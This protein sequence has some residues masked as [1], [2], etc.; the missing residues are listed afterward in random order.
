M[1]NAN[2]STPR[3]LSPPPSDRFRFVEVELDQDVLGEDRSSV[4]PSTERLDLAATPAASLTKGGLGKRLAHQECLDFR[5]APDRWTDSRVGQGRA[6][7]R[8]AARRDPNSRA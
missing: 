2:F 5:Q 6:H 7:D 3:L 8:A 1:A 4:V